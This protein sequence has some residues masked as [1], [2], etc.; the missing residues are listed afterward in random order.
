MVDDEDS[1]HSQKLISAGE[2]DQED[3]PIERL[4]AKKLSVQS[5]FVITLITRLF[6]N[7]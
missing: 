1:D 4:V 7:H 2:S 3:S 5:K 6:N